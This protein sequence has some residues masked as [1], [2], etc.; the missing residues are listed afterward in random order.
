MKDHTHIG[1]GGDSDPG[2]A[3]SKAIRDWSDFTAFEYSAAWG[4]F[5]IAAGKQMR[6]GPLRE[7]WL[8]EVEATPCR[9]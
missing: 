2:R 9:L 8:C 6:C 7:A 4:N 3:Q 5:A 1:K